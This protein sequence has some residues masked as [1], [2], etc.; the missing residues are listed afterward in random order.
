MS[1]PDISFTVIPQDELEPPPYMWRYLIVTSAGRKYWSYTREL[2]AE[3][4]AIAIEYR[5]TKDYKWHNAVPTR[6][7]GVIQHVTVNL[8]SGQF[9]MLPP[10]KTPFGSIF[11]MQY[12][13]MGGAI[14]D[15]MDKFRAHR[16]GRG[17]GRTR[18]A[19]GKRKK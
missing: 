9:A 13:A 8:P 7:D 19:S 11:K 14:R 18:K 16:K 6:K 12:Q 15:T 2:V 1:L 17:V 3:T 4:N 5:P 10:D